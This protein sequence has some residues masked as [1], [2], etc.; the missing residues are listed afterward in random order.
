MVEVA[1][2]GLLE[3]ALVDLDRVD[4]GGLGTAALSFEVAAEAGVIGVVPGRREAVAEIAGGP[5][6][7]AHANAHRLQEVERRRTVQV[8][9]QGRGVRILIGRETIHTAPPT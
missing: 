4:A 5:V 9:R 7:H 1:V 2:E 3:H 6:P 8:A